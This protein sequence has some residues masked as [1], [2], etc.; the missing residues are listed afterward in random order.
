[1]VLIPGAPGDCMVPP[2]GIALRSFVGMPFGQD[3]LNVLLMMMGFWKED[4]RVQ[5]Q[6]AAHT[7]KVQAHT[8]KA[9]HG[10]WFQ[11]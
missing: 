11:Y 8:V 4:F 10:H 6:P 2:D 1:M 3:V 5:V 9:E 7:T